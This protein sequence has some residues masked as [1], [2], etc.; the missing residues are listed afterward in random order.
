LEFA[1]AADSLATICKRGEVVISKND[2]NNSNSNST[3]VK[4]KKAMKVFLGGSCNPTT[5]RKNIAIPLLERAGVEYYNPQVDE[6]HDDLI[7]IEARN[8]EE[9]AILFFVLDGQTRSIASMVE[10]A[11][12]V[13]LGRTVVL[14][15]EDIPE[16][17]M[18]DGQ[19][20]VGR[21][22]KD[23]NRGRA[24]TADVANRHNVKP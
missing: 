1:T 12:F 23:L 6:W 13:S 10:I 16:G 18:I 15:I 3:A 22:L 21:E 9:A 4:K 14:V 17:Q 24:Y 8:K 19:S 2:R 11:E 5:W 7:A 20:I